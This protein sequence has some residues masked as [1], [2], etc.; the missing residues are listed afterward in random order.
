MHSPLS[1]ATHA[2]PPPRPAPA[3]SI[4]RGAWTAR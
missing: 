3:R 4:P 1:L 2:F